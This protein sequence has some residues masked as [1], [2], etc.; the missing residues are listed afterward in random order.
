MEGFESFELLR[1]IEGEGRY[2]VY[3][4]WESEEAFQAWLHSDAF[5]K[6]HAGGSVGSSEPAD[7]DHGHG[8]GIRRATQADIPALMG[9]L[10]RWARDLHCW[11]SKWL[12]RSP[13]LNN[14]EWL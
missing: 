13:S 8:A 11:D 9:R 12:C 10:D 7:G 4:R 6:G 1:P 14:S 2:F 5:T 3:T